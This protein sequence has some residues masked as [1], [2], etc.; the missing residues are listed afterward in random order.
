MTN[1]TTPTVFATTHDVV[2]YSDGQIIGTVNLTADQFAEY[3]SQAQQPEGLV[4][5]KSLP[6][7]VLLDEN[8]NEDGTVYL[9]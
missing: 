1:P 6:S 5:L 9:D 8:A 4:L 7:V 3:E 2:R